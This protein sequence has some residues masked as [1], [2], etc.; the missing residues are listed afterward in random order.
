MDC[1][2]LFKEEFVKPWFFCNVSVVD[3]NR[4]LQNAAPFSAVVRNLDK[5]PFERPD[6]DVNNLRFECSYLSGA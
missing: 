1:P 3:L 6:A 4:E 2:T 5:W